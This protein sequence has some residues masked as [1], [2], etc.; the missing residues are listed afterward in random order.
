MRYSILTYN[1]TRTSVCDTLVLFS[2][3]VRNIQILQ[4]QKTPYPDFNE[5]ELTGITHTAQTRKRVY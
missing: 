4:D 3:V 5:N 1:E 2:K